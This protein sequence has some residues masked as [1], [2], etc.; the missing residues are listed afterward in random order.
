MGLSNTELRKFIIES[1]SDEELDIFCFD[2][3]PE[4]FGENEGALGRSR[5]AIN[6]I[7]YC[8]HRGRQHDLETALARE[9]PGPWNERFRK[10][11][12]HGDLPGMETIRKNVSA[13][14]KSEE[15]KSAL[16]VD[17]DALWRNQI[18][19]PVLKSA[20]PEMTV[21]TARSLNEA[22][23]KFGKQQ[24]D[25]L[26]LDIRLSEELDI[27]HGLMLLDELRS[28]NQ[29]PLRVVVVSAYAAQHGFLA[30]KKGVDAF[31]RKAEFD[32]WNFASV[33]Q[34]LLSLKSDD[35]HDKKS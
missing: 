27:P 5:K 13:Q 6:L 3:F 10:S 16:I 23:S 19:A 25:L 34:R 24:Y 18:I 1:F 29:V 30:G 26:V 33:V 9:R 35:S 12:D 22:K 20:F 11:T 2:H 14:A 31:I 32:D 7:R 15:K 8:Q 17:D 4:V 21:H 28:T